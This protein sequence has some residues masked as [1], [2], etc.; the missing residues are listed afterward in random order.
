MIKTK[1]NTLLPS[2]IV[3]GWRIYIDYLKLNKVARKDNFLL[4]FL[5]QMLNRLAGHEY[6]CFLDGYSGYNQISISLEDQEK[7]TFTCPCGT[8]SVA[9][10]VM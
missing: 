8:F 6:Y 9:F 1:N 7:V 4:M 10:W 3:T 2:Q 5:D